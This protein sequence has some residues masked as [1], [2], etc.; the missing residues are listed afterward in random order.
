MAYVARFAVV[1]L[2]FLSCASGYVPAMYADTEADA[3]E[4]GVKAEGSKLQLQW[5]ENG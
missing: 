4:A 3:I 1:L 5:Y 2:L